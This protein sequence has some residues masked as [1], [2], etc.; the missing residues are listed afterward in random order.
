MDLE[1]YNEEN[2]NDYIMEEEEEENK[3]KQIKEKSFQILNYEIENIKNI[4]INLKNIYTIK[5]VS[6]IDDN[7]FCIFILLNNKLIFEIYNIYHIKYK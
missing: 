2:D 3:K 7:K 1:E 4:K 5:N 6:K